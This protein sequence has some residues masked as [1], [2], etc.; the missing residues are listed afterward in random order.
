MV[1]DFVQ[2]FPVLR[3]PDGGQLYFETNLNQLIVEPW[4]AASSLT[5]LIPAF[6][7]L[8]RIR[9]EW[10][11][12]PFFFFCQFLLATGGIGSALYHAFRV[13]EILMLLDVLPITILTLALGCNFWLKVTRSLG[14]AIWL[15]VA[16]FFVRSY[17]FFITDDPNG[18]NFAYF[19]SG[20]N[21]GVPIVIILWK[22]RW[23]GA[24]SILLSILFCLLALYF[25]VID[26]EA[27]AWMMIGT[28][29]LWHIFCSFGA[30]YLS[31]YLFM[32][33]VERDFKNI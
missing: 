9:K 16:F 27:P 23:L 25:R 31:K 26:F 24:I 28:H 22:T 17:F 1:E 15:N 4:N 20:V 32:T 3:P 8:Y 13:S 12:H 10:K 6:Y 18:I 19:L 2:H 14:V 11:A 29:W 21:L 30:Y 33:S 7:W 5:F